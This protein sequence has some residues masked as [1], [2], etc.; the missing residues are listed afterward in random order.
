MGDESKHLHPW[1]L[2]DAQHTNDCENKWNDDVC[3]GDECEISIG[4][5]SH[6]HILHIRGPCLQDYDVRLID[7]LLQDNTR[8]HQEIF[9]EALGLKKVYTHLS[10]KDLPVLICQSSSLSLYF[11][12]MLSNG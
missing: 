11:P 1:T 7:E 6:Y 8:S 10:R 12:L 9:D 3:D 5:A 4:R 2:D